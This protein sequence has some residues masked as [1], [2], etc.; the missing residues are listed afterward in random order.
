MRNSRD[1]RKSTNN[2]PSNWKQSKKKRKTYRLTLRG[3]S[4]RQ[5]A[6]TKK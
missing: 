4:D 1:Y 2:S 5:T 6:E 3:R